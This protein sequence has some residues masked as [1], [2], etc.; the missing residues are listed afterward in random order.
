[1]LWWGRSVGEAMNSARTAKRDPE[2]FCD[3]VVEQML[4]SEGPADDVALLAVATKH[5]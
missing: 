4:G 3:A 1:M 5:A 2:A